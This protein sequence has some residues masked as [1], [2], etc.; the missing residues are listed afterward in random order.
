MKRFAR[1]PSVS[2]VVLLAALGPVQAADEAGKKDPAAKVEPKPESAVPT[3]RHRGL[4][5]GLRSKKGETTPAAAVKEKEAAKPTKPDPAPLPATKVKPTP[6]KAAP[7]VGETKATE[8]PKQKRGRGIFGGPSQKKDVPLEPDPAEAK[9]GTE[10]TKPTKAEDVKAKKDAQ[11]TQPAPSGDPKPK[12]RGPFGLFGKHDGESEAKPIAQ[13][14]PKK[15]FRWPWSQ[16]KEIPVIEPD[17]TE[18]KA[19]KVPAPVDPTSLLDIKPREPEA[20][21]APPSAPVQPGKK[22]NPIDDIGLAP[23]R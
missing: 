14:K 4:F 20:A 13:P 15:K 2:L 19:E 11:A 6:E 12:R 17:K 1:I 3:K 5:D 16:E 21:L 22:P 8:P 9:Q 23:D 7:V 10:P 18:P